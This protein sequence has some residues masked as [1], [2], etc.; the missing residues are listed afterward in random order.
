MTRYTVIDPATGRTL[1]KPCGTRSGE[2]RPHTPGLTVAERA[3]CLSRVAD[4][5]TERRERLAEIIVGEMD[6]PAT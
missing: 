4:L 2:P 1:K 6:N 3:G 5:H